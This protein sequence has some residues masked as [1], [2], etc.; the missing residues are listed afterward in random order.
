MC[1]IEEPDI[2]VNVVDMETYRT[3]GFVTA[4]TDPDH[5]IWIS[6][7]YDDKVNMGKLYVDV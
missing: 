1:K 3:W 2:K 4:I 5:E 6:I 7:K